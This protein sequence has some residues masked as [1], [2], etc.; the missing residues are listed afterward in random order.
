MALEKSP[1]WP[2]L[3]R[4]YLEGRTVAFFCYGNEAGTKLM[5]RDDEDPRLPTVRS[6]MPMERNRRAGR[7]L[8]GRTHGR[9]SGLGY[10]PPRHGLADARLAWRDLRMRIGRAR[11]GS[12]A[13]I[14]QAQG[15]NQD[16]TLKPKQSEARRY[17]R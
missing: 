11:R 9:G 14:Q 10:Q 7:A 12:S 8:V 15:L 2:T 3:T 17:P 1:E 13:A 4:N 5:K 6:A 16:A